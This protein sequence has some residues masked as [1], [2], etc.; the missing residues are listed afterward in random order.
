M[1]IM[2]SS[3]RDFNLPEAYKQFSDT[4]ILARIGP[5]VDWNSLKPM[6]S[7]FTATIRLREED[8]I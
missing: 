1:H 3:L 4:D 5:L 2:V 7:H 6:V 8:Q